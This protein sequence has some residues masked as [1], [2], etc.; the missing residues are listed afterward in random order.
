MALSADVDRRSL[1]CAGSAQSARVEGERE[2]IRNGAHARLSEYLRHIAYAS[3]RSAWGPIYDSLGDDVAP[4]LGEA[5]LAEV[6]AAIDRPMN[7]WDPLTFVPGRRSHATP[8]VPAATTAA[9]TGV[10]TSA[11]TATA[12]VT[13]TT[14]A[15]R[16]R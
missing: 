8:S 2:V 4:P 14:A 1:S 9:T 10:A 13:T 7:Q 3:A 16:S 6:T 15:A 5:G 11:T 12:T